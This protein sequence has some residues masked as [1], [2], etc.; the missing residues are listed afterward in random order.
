MDYFKKFRPHSWRYI[1]YYKYQL[2]YGK[3]FKISF[4]KESQLLEERLN[5]LKNTNK[6]QQ[7]DVKR[8]LDGIKVSKTCI[9]IVATLTLWFQA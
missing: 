7:I 3:D 6:D 1:S 8:L 5:T 2:A 4:T 9:Y